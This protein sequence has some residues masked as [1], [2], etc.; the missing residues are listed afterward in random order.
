MTKIATIIP[1][2]Q[3]EPGILRKALASIYAQRLEPDRRVDV[4]IVDDAS[5][6]PPDLDLT[7]PPPPQF[8][9]RVLRRENGGPGAARNTGLDAVPPDTDFIAFLDSD[10]A[11]VPDHLERAL[12][13][14]GEDRNFYFSDQEITGLTNYATHFE[15]LRSLSGEK[16]ALFC[17]LPRAIVVANNADVCIR[18]PLEN[19][20][21]FD[22]TT[23][24]TALLR[25]FLP[26]IS[27]TV[28]RKK[29]LGN[30][31]FCVSLR[32]SGE[33]YL[34]F[35]LLANRTTNVCYSRR[36]GV[37]RGRGVSIFHD[38]VSWD[39]PQSVFVV[40][41]AL[42]CFLLAKKSL[43]LNKT[44][45]V[46]L[47]KRLHF[48]RLEAVSRLLADIRRSKI[49]LANVRA[50]LGADTSLIVRAPYLACI[51]VWRKLNNLPVSDHMRSSELS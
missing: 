35:L 24:L 5:P 16:E 26:H 22:G 30:V 20:F 4:I 41:D 11:W 31:R 3:R 18:S 38:A 44:Q 33:D 10:D 45:H 47:Q 21:V 13:T 51:A 48:R 9:V 17:G 25:A 14:L 15:S 29:P 39:S 7:D 19:S 1:Y 42:K 37:V 28:I 50:I 43:N 49:C 32:H 8:S 34:Y 12:A 40:S 23:G 36:A 6:S 27:V 2:Y 46:I